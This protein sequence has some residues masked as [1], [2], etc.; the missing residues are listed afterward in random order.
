MAVQSVFY[1]SGFGENAD[2]VELKNLN[3]KKDFGGYYLTAKFQVEDAHSIR[4]LDIPR[5]RLSIVP[6]EVYIH[7]IDS[8]F[9]TNAYINLGFGKLPLDYGISN[10]YQ[11]FYTEKI[12]EEKYT[13]MTMDEIEKKLGYKVKIMNK[14]NE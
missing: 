6:N 9:E 2:K 13:E 7:S 11:A 12:L 4:E 14:K 1:R 8:D 10:G 3:L 5:I